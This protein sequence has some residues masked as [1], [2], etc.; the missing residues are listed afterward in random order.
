MHF[1]V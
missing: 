1:I